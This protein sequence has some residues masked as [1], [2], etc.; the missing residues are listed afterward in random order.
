MGASRQPSWLS[1]EP[2]EVDPDPLLE[3]LGRSISIPTR[4]RLNMFRVGLRTPTGA[5]RLLPDFMIIG[6]QRGG[7]S[8]LFKYLSYH[9]EIRASIR[10]EVEYFNRFRSQHGVSWYRAHFPLVGERLRAGKAGRQL[11]TF[12][13][14][15]VYL[16]HPH[17][18]RQVAELMPEIKLIVLLRDPIARA[19]SHYHHM[20]RLRLENLP[21]AQAIHFEEERIHHARAKVFADPNYFSRIY[22]RVCYA[23]RG[24]YAEHLLRWFEHFSRDRLCPVMSEDLFSNPAAVLER[25]LTFLG[26][27]PS[28][29]PLS[30]TNY[31]YRNGPRVA[32]RDMDA[33][34]RAFL[35]EKF[36]PHN[37]RLASLVGPE[38][39]W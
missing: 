1:P 24:F 22:T 28:W 12:E 39:R 32:Y 20:S 36:A 25:I 10:K 27:D 29:R 2:V 30:F 13:A 11:L 16:D 18:P 26:V 17:T 37:E 14:T 34:T 33:T 31:S 8:S 3:K 5:W 6:T 7:T 15:P 38:F 19:L 23:Y 21:F 9:P 35:E 4:R